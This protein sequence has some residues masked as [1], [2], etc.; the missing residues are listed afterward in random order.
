MVFIRPII[1]R[2]ASLEGDYRGYRAF[3]PDDKFMAAPNPGK[4]APQGSPR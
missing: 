2:D 1:V 3:L 4:P